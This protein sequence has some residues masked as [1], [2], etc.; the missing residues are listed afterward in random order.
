MY[1]QG[2]GNYHQSEAITGTLPLN[3]N[4]PQQCNSGLYAEQLSGTA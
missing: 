3:Q 4:S 1:M 2:F